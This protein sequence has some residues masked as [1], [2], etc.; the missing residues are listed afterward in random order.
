MKMWTFLFINVQKG[1]TNKQVQMY[2]YMFVSLQSGTKTI[3]VNANAE[4]EVTSWQ[5]E[6]IICAECRSYYFNIGTM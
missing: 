3:T 6:Y 5:L 1:P 2:V 4:N